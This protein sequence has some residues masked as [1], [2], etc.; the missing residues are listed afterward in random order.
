ML[1]RIK[2]IWF[3]IFKKGVK[4]PDTVDVFDRNYFES[5]LQEQNKRLVHALGR[6]S[7]LNDE[8]NILR[9]ELKRFKSDVASDV[10]YLTE[11]FG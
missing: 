9:N 5:R 6:I 7:A 4:M 1:L 8:V 11:K 2:Q 3:S 10:Q